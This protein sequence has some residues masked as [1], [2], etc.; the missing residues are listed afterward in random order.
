MRQGITQSPTEP[1][2][3]DIIKQRMKLGVIASGGSRSTRRWPRSV[4]WATVMA[5]DAVGGPPGAT[6]RAAAIHGEKS[7][8]N[9]P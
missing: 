1:L 2:T 8:L 6:R 3:L 7:G 5:F 9:R 4:A